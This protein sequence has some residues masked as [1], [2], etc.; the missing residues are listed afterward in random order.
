M[1]LDAGDG[2]GEGLL[3]GHGQP[4][5]VGASTQKD[6]W[7]ILS[8]NPATL[9][10]MALNQWK[11]VAITRKGNIW[12]G[13]VDGVEQFSTTATGPL[14]QSSGAPTVRIGAAN[15]GCGYAMS[16]YLDDVRITKGRAIYASNFTPATAAAG[17]SGVCYVD[18]YDVGTINAVGTGWCSSTNM[19]YVSGAGVPG[20]D[21]SGTGL[22][23]DGRHYVNGVPVP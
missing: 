12:K 18:G 5:T 11:H 1:R 20:L 7:N 3:F 2:T 8:G 16:G 17:K 4:L 15:S 23:S 6:V 10:D 21:S 22:G 19:F 13:F 14:Y 9:T